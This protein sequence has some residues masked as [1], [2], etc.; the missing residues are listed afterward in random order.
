MVF[1]ETACVIKDICRRVL[2]ADEDNL[3]CLSSNQTRSNV[4][5]RVIH[6]R[7]PEDDAIKFNVDGSFH[8]NSLGI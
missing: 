3:T 5:S 7:V 1:G 4:T 8:K 6:G 2:L